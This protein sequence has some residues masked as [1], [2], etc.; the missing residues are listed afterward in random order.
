LRVRAVEALLSNGL[1]D[2]FLVALHDRFGGASKLE[3]SQSLYDVGEN[4]VRI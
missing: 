3:G 4:R 1:K 2:S